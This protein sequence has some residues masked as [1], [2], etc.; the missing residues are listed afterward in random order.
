[1]TIIYSQNQGGNGTQIISDDTEIPPDTKSILYEDKLFNF[2]GFYRGKKT[3]AISARSS[4]G[5][6]IKITNLDDHLSSDKKVFLFGNKI[7][8]ENDKVSDS[9]D[10]NYVTKELPAQIADLKRKLSGLE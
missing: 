5:A 4:I 3:F 10:I 8:V 7:F 9:V 1:M 2:L 6:L